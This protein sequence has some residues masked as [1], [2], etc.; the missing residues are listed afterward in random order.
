MCVS[1]NVC[2]NVCVIYV[3]MC[4]GSDVYAM[5]AGGRIGRSIM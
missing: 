5:C 3:C 1:A 4:V 2:A